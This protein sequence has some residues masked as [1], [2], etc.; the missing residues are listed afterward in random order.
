MKRSVT[1]ASS[2]LRIGGLVSESRDWC[3]PALL[4]VGACLLWATA[5]RQEVRDPSTI[6]LENSQVRRVLEKDEDTWRTTSFS[7]ADGSHEVV[8]ESD[9]FRILLMDGTKLSLKDYRVQRDPVVRKEEDRSHIQIEYVPR[10]EPHPEAPQSILMEYSLAEEPYLRKT[11]TLTLEEG[12]AVDRLE[13]ERFKTGLVCDRGGI[14]QPI[15]LAD[16]WFVGLEYPGSFTEHNSGRVILAHYPGLAKK[17]EGKWVIRSK[18][19]VAGVPRAGDSLELGFHDY[20]ETIRQPAPKHMLANTW[21]VDEDS[22]GPRGYG[23]KEFLDYYDVFD[24]NL[25]PYGVK[26]DSLQPD[27]WKFD[28]QSAS[29][30]HK[31]LY[32]GGYG[33]LRE[34]LEARGSTLS[35]WLALN[36]TAN[37][38]EWM[39]KEGYERANGPFDIFYCV[40]AP[41]LNTATRKALKNAIEEGNVSYFKH[42]FVQMMCSLEGHGHLPTYRHGFEAN[43]DATLELMAYERQLNPSVL[44]APTSYVW[45]S[46]WWLMHANYIFMGISDYG[47]VS[48]WPQLSYRE[49]EMTYRDDQFFRIYKQWRIP[50]PM[51]PMITHTFLPYRFHRE[52]GQPETLREWTD[53]SAMVFGRGVRLIDIYSDGRKLSAE[54]WEALGTFA[55]WYEDH[56]EVLGETRMVGGNPR[57]GQVY[58]FVHWKGESGI[59]CL[60]NPDVAEQAIRVPFDKSVVYREE[61]GRPFR[62]R[63]VYPFVEDLPQLFT[64]GEP[65]LFQ[66]PGYTVMLIELEPGQAHQVTPAQPAGLIEGTGSALPEERDW[67]N[68]YKA[69]PTL[70]LTAKVSLQVPDEEMAR[71][72]LFLIARSNG[73][74]PKFPTLTLNG[75]AAQFH[76]VEGA[77]DTPGEGRVPRDTDTINWSIHS[78]DVKEFR[79]KDVEMVA[80]SSEN[81]VP[82]L[83]DVWVVADRPVRTAP[84]PEG[85]LPPT[86]WQDYRRQT[87]KLLSYIL[88]RVPLHH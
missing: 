88:G 31:R 24:R 16:S 39:R 25:A 57:K 6:V 21:V 8:V 35:L 79:G 73:A 18:T 37:N 69:Y 71:C 28:P 76:A 4:L 42:D 84:V 7:R 80:I 56:L 83:L 26:L 72:D 64:S 32:P 85:N 78:I 19:A 50:Y 34:Q 9:E 30:P 23:T 81:P 40:S 13:V 62:G 10:G 22:L 59:L 58:G 49:W 67:S 1:P 51:S 60:R 11:L 41:K 20:L 61:V 63:V 52:K 12:E 45:L 48:T 44:N 55:R 77:G 15:F 29:L 53:L 54:F 65:M 5:C 66:V 36:G 27:F 17:E 33:P 3:W 74:L 68:V 14:G 43:L 87:V 46:P 70:K 75:E 86:F 2:R 47:A 82:F 38:V